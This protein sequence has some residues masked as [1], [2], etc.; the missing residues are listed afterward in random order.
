[1]KEIDFWFTVGSTYTYL[2]VMR[3]G[4]LEAKNKIRF[5][6]RPFSVRQLM[7]EQAGNPF[8]NND[9]KMAYMQRDVERRA[10]L[11]GLAIK[12][13][14]PYPIE[15]FE[16]T[17][18]I[19][20]LGAQE[21]WCREFVCRC[22]HYWFGEG[23]VAGSPVNLSRSLD[24]IGQDPARVIREASSVAVVEALEDA[25]NAARGLGLFGTPNF[26]VGDEVFWGDDRAEDAIRFAQTGGF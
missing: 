6:M 19:A 15:K 20:V 7:Q 12:S 4:A 14:V 23:L 26:L 1:M 22:Y 13:P 24:D 21:G 8:L 11:Y 17:N 25:T 3:L 16:L 10:L 2:S 18:Q 5:N 9:K